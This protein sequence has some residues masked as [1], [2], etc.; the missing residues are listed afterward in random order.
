MTL[1]LALSVALLASEAI[2]EA[3]LMAVEQVESSGRGALTPSGDKGKA[4]GCLQWHSVA[5]RD[6]SAIRRKAGLKVYPYAD[7]ANPVKARDYARTWLTA[8]KIRLAAQIG[9]QPFPGEIWLAWNMGYTGF[10]RYGFQWADVPAEKFDK[11]RQVNALAWGGS[12]GL[13]KPTR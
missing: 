13:P 4:I 6:C 8:L 11:A 12:K 3:T 1:V 9:R 7:A 10:S 5:W 2:P